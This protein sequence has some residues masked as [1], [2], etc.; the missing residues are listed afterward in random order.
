MA[1]KILIVD[2]EESIRKLVSEVLADEGYE[3]ITASDGF[4]GIKKI[5]EETPELVIVDIMMPNLNGYKMIYD[6]I[7]E[8]NMEKTPYFIILSV[9]SSEVDKGLGERLGACAYLEKPFK[10]EELVKLVKEALN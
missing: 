5:K 6:I 10:R 4:K 2:D 8:E 1:E 7:N 3:V 9:R